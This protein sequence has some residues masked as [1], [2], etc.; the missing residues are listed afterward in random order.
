MGSA[1]ESPKGVVES[2]DE[3]A[4]KAVEGAVKGAAEAVAGA[5]EAVG[6]AVVTAAEVAQKTA[7][8][9]ELTGIAMVVLAALLCGM[10]ME[11]LRQPALVG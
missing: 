4:V 11:R 10:A 2:T 6:G 5:A 3:S 7:H 9:S 1:S 8:I